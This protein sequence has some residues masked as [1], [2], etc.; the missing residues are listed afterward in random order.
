MVKGETVW[1]T[2][3]AGGAAKGTLLAQATVKSG[4]PAGT[5]LG[6]FCSQHGRAMSGSLATPAIEIDGT[7]LNGTPTWVPRGGGS[8]ANVAVKPGDTI[9]WKAISATHGVVFDTEAVAQAFLDFQSGGGLPPLG[10]QVVKG[11]PAWGTAPL[12]AQG[13]GTLLARATVKP[14][15]APG[16][17]LGFFCSQHGRAMSG[18]L[19]TS[20]RPVATVEIDGNI[21]NGTPTWMPRAGGSAANVAVKPGDTIVWK[22]DLR[23]PR[24]RLRHR[25]DR[26]GLPRLPVRRRTAGRLAPQVV[27]G[28]TV[29]G[30]APLARRAR[31]PSWPRPPSSP[32][33]PPGT[34]LGFFCSQHGR[35]MSGSPWRPAQDG[36]DRR[37]PSS[38]TLA[39][40][41]APVAT[42]EIDGTILNGTPTWVPRG[43]GSAAS[44]AVK[45][46]D[47]I[48]WKAT[49][50]THGVVFDTEAI[51]QAFLDFQ[52]GGGL[53]ALGPQVVKGETVWGTAP[54][55]AQGQGTLL[56]RATV[57]PGVAPGTTSASSAA[58]T[59][60]P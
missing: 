16:T 17:T 37:R 28:E 22:A 55:A 15:V 25:G 2:A 39:T 44:V 29:W 32:A 18:S 6:F 35:A 57:K 26:P 36:R 20:R 38:G 13:Q 21:L 4:V 41:G 56:A 1:G 14:G 60:A 49:S 24:R 10:P 12:A 58:S 33:S 59:A 53:P 42:V 31:A 30:T 7:I 45:P 9:V 50:A 11:Q 5:T 43:G 52:S 51:A 40:P 34:T 48:V 54:L 19:A 23:H 8:A 3:A 46:G 47:T 27:K